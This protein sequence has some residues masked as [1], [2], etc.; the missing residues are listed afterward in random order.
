MTE[1]TEQRPA[2]AMALI[3]LASS[4]IASTTLIAKLVSSGQLGTPLHPLQVSQGRFLFGFMAIS[5]LALGLRQPFSRPNWRLHAARTTSGWGGISLM[6]AAVSFI[7]LADATAIS[8]LNPVFAMILSIPLLGERVGRVRWGA[9]AVALLGALILLRPSPGSFQP[10]ALLALAAA[11][12]LGLEVTLIKRLAGRE[13][14]IQILVINN[15]FGAL[16]ATA[17]AAWVWQEATAAQWLALAALGSLMV[18]AQ[19]C[20]TNA[21]RLADASFVAPLTYATLAFAALY[22]FL[23]FGVR[24]DAVTLTGAGIILAGGAT[25]AWREA[26]ARLRA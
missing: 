14:P 5:V 22:D 9:A 23:A 18:C 7:P 19:I 11:L 6:F 24:P 26:R 20:Y 17:A 2:L 10:G 1:Q 21:L 25:L 4:L 13:R 15:G 8:F 12:A 3:L 16:I